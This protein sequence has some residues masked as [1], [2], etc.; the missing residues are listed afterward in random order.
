MQR[1]LLYC[2]LASPALYALADV[3]AGVR[4]HGYSFRDQTISELGAIGAP[5]R[6]LFATLL[7][8]VYALLL[9]FGIGIRRASRQ[10]GR[11]RIVGGLVI[12][13]A[14]LALTVGQFA[15]MRPRGTP[16]GLAGTMHLTEGAIAML[17][18]FLAM[19]LAATAFGAR[20]RLYTWATFG[21]VLVLGA[22]TARATGAVEAG[23]QTPW[24]GAQE[25]LWWYAYQLWFA[26]LA[27]TLLREPATA[28]P[29]RASPTD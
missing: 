20:F 5:S 11:V 2:G 10:R 8:V 16:Q 19:G 3:L 14:T 7:L 12:A 22:W 21:L 23:G 28:L 13:L 9:A 4:W 27:L 18:V 29:P 25:R 17:I 26:V 24:L 6:P 15:A 1:F